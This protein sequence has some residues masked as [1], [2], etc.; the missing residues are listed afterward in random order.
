M[1]GR[2]LE[3]LL[4]QDLDNH[5]IVLVDDGSRDRT[6]EIAE[7]HLASGRLTIVR[8][9]MNRGCPHARNLGIRHA[10]G[11]ILAFIDGDGFAAPSWLRNLVA[12]FDRD[13]TVGGVASTVFMDSN[14]LVLNGAGGIV[15]RQGWA[16]D[17][18][19]NVPYESAVLPREALYPMGCGMAVRRSAV[20][21]VGPFDDTMLNYYDDVDYG[22]RLWRAGYRVVV[23]HDAW[24]DHGFGHSSGGDSPQKQLLCEQHRM[25]VVLKHSAVSTLA[26]WTWHELLAAR[27]AGWPRRELKR[28]ALR[29]NLRHLPSTL[30]VRWR[31]RAAPR[32]PSRLIDP[33]WGEDFPAGVP[34]LVRPEPE[35]AGATV[36]MAVPEVEEL[37]PYGWFP[38]EKIRER[39]YRWSARKSSLLV[40]LQ[41]PVGKLRLEYAHAPQDIGGVALSIHRVGAVDPLTAV[42]ETKLRWQ[43]T[44]RAVENHPLVLPAGD[45]EV[46]FAADA[47]WSDP[48]REFRELAFALSRLAFEDAPPPAPA[49]LDMSTPG[50]D[51]QLVQHWFEPEQIGERAYRW[52][53]AGASAIVHLSAPARSMRIMYCLPPASIGAVEVAACRVGRARPSWSSTIEW[54]D[55][56]WHT[57][58]VACRL[59]PGD[60]VVSFHPRSTWSNPGGIDSSRSPENRSLG[61]A[62]AEISFDGSKATAS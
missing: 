59:G 19:M 1:I 3:H 15:N 55:G 42:W 14:P 23:A 41:R 2:C 13:P 35:D 38:A 31:L 52:G 6:V 27:R 58:S 54:R 40:S 51:A 20:D 57:E 48:P 30:R 16:A 50:A 43:F 8:S 37:L 49:G 32:V 34:K 21:R 11:E 28:Q 44:E 29:W 12:Q 60:Y 4:A 18:L 47:T 5:E 56:S 53:G 24:I 36:D 17:M 22:V 25:R 61:I 39:W 7:R 33:S 45:Y 9:P 62:V 26:R 46:R 10:R